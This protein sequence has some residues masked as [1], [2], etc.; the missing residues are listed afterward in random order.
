MTKNVFSKKELATIK[1]ALGQARGY[2]MQNNSKEVHTRQ[3]DCYMSA[4]IPEL[5]QLEGLLL[6]ADLILRK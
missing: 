5:N 6:E 1:F 4:D 2:V 3:G